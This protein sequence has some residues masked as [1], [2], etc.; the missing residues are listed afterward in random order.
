[1]FPAV[2]ETIRCPT[3]ILST[4]GVAFGGG[5][6]PVPSAAAIIA[7]SSNCDV[8]GVPGEEPISVPNALPGAPG[9]LEVA[10]KS[11]PHGIQSCRTDLKT[12]WSMLVSRRE[13]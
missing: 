6:E 1:M 7:G 12:I 13:C 11:S 8:H 3:E 9:W 4:G 2:A 10:E 5:A